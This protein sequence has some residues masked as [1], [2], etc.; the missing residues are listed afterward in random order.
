MHATSNGL[1][2]IGAA[3]ALLGA[4]APTMAAEGK[5]IAQS[6][7]TTCHVLP[8]QEGMPVGPSFTELAKRTDYTAKGL[9]EILATEQHAEVVPVGQ[10]ELSA[11]VNYL[12]RIDGN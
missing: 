7:C 11:L 9:E 2:A 12:N 6:V 1:I 5:Q 3:S 8:S 4:G 10:L